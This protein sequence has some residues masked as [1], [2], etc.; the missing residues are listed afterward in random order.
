MPLVIT[1][2]TRA[3]WG[4]LK[5][6]QSELQ[7][8][9][10]QLSSWGSGQIGQL[11]GMLGAY[12]GIDAALS[13]LRQIKAE[14]DRLQGL[15]RTWSPQ[16]AQAGAGADIAELQRDRAQG[17]AV[18]DIATKRE[19]LRE[20]EAALAA[21]PLGASAAQDAA[22]FG[23]KVDTGTSAVSHFWQALVALAQ[24]DMDRAGME[25]SVSSTRMHETF[26]AA[27]DMFMPAGVGQLSAQQGKFVEQ[28]ALDEL[29]RIAT[30]TQGVR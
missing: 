2:D 28:M 12:F 13:G 22:S 25:A 8:M 23:M 7:G 3:A 5:K 20:R 17:L 30:N 21:G 15:A 29:R 27:V 26:G 18:A 1:S 16:V 4:G 9:H 24:G 14:A 11:G 6:A 19:G 10:R